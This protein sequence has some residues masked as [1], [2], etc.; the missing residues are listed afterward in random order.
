[1]KKTILTFIF[2]IIFISCSSTSDKQFKRVNVEQFYRQSGM[3]KYFLSDLPRWANLSYEGNCQRSSSKKFFNIKNIMESFSMNYEEAIHFQ[4]LFNIEYRIA[5]E[6]KNTPPTLKEEESLF[7]QT[8]D[9]VKAGIRAFKKPV[10]DRVN[11]VWVD[12]FLDNKASLRKL[13]TSEAM[14]LG[15]PLLVSMCHNESELKSILGQS[16][17]FYEGS[18]FVTFEAF[19][20]YNSKGEFGARENLYLD[21]ILKK[22]QK[23]FF[24]YRGN[25][26][27]N[28]FGKF[29]LRKIQ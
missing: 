19:S 18:R 16:K 26:P 4:Y 21:K 5:K 13:M 14:N 10:F 11:I 22:N 28:L 9:K 25:K 3:V 23:K 24:Y 29:N 17:V 12:S 8:L 2:T 7:F 20:Y 6:K 1:M 15:R 27:K